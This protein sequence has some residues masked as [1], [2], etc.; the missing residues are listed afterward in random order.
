MQVAGVVAEF[1]CSGGI[2]RTQAQPGLFTK[3]HD[4]SV[5]M[6]DQQYRAVGEP[7]VARQCDRAIGAAV[8][9]DA[10]APT[11]DIGRGNL[12]IFDDALVPDLMEPGG[13]PGFRRQAKNFCELQHDGMISGRQWCGGIRL[14]F[15]VGK[16]KMMLCMHHAHTFELCAT[17]KCQVPNT[18]ANGPPDKGSTIA[19]TPATL[20]RTNTV[21]RVC[22][23]NR[24][25]AA[26][27]NNVRRK[28]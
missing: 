14:N 1:Y 23:L 8:A 12:K 9:G 28:R 7:G 3:A 26:T 11:T 20:C 18:V 2:E 19:Q 25:G 22:R 13:K 4:D 21:V 6:P 10:Q 24:T 5:I 15:A 16:S 17:G 27:D